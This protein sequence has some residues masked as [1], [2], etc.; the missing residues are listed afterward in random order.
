MSLVI[1]KGV[2]ARMSTSRLSTT[3]ASRVSCF[4]APGKM[5]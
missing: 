4:S 3:R 2:P 1:R 5:R